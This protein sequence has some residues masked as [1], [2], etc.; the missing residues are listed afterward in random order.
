MKFHRV[1]EHRPAVAWKTLSITRQGTNLVAMTEHDEVF[2]TT[3]V[4]TTDGARELS[5]NAFY[6]ENDSITVRHDYHTDT[7]GKIYE[8][9]YNPI[10][11]D[12]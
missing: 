1:V 5:K 4:C 10:D 2:A 8:K 9:P 7:S 3:D 6:R 11:D 12:D